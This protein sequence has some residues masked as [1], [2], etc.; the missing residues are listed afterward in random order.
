MTTKDGTEELEPQKQYNL[1]SILE[2][3]FDIKLENKNITLTP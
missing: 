3:H 1:S 2:K